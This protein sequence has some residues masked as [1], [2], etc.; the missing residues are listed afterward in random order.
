MATRRPPGPDASFFTNS[1]DQSVSEG[2]SIDLNPKP[3]RPRNVVGAG[4]PPFPH[5][6][7]QQ[8]ATL[9]KMLTVRG[10]QPSGPTFVR[11]TAQGTWQRPAAAVVAATASCRLWRLCRTQQQQQALQKGS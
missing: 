3:K 5:H 8:R 7:G 6:G 1:L 11:T 9:Q 10:R 4:G 2:P